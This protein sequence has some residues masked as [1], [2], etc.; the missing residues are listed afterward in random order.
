MHVTDAAVIAGCGAEA[1][2]GQLTRLTS[3]HLSIDRGRRDVHFRKPLP[4]P[5]LQ[6]QL[7]GCSAH[8]DN[9]GGSGGGRLALSG[10]NTSLQELMLEFS[11]HLCDDELAAAAAAL[12][13][14]RRLRLGDSPS[15]MIPVCGLRGVGLAAFST[16]RRLRDISLEFCPELDPQQ[17]ATLLPDMRALASLNL[18]KCPRLDSSSV[19]KLQVAFR[20]KQGRTL[21]VVQEDCAVE[22]V[23]VPLWYM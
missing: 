13:D 9:A 23:P 8:A 21:Q 14:L 1:A 6:L 5:P 16:C 22:S 4:E 11:G 2:I 10:R 15:A 19:R 17:I 7:L 20:A 18:E 12:P 3:L